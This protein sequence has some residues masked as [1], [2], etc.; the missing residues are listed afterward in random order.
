MTALVREFLTKLGKQEPDFEERKR[1][2]EEIFASIQEFR[3]VD[4][5]A[6]GDVHRRPFRT[7]RPR[8]RT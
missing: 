6:R 8:R 5:L 3:A 1:L 2:Q 7:G 4:P